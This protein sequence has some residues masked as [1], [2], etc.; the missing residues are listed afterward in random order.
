MNERHAKTALV[1]AVA[2]FMALVVWNNLAD[3]GSNLAFVRHVLLMDTTFPDNRLRWRALGAEWMH[4]AFYAAIIVWE[5]AAVALTVNLLL[6]FGAFLL[7]GGEWF[8][9]WQSE[10]WNGQDAAFR[11][12]AVVGLILLFVRAPEIAVVPP[13]AA[14]DP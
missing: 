8:V 2:A 1:A 5:F 11:M 6:W 13:F 10:T 9:M 14:S 3:Y 7:V 4:H 12:F